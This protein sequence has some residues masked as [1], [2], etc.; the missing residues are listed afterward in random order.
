MSEAALC[1]K[2]NI[3]NVL[4]MLVLADHYN[5][6]TVRSVALKLVRENVKGIVKQEGWRKKLEKYP[7]IISDI[8]DATVA[9]Q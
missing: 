7:G 6:S 1:A 5:A 9:H 4:N 2:L 3:G 8:H